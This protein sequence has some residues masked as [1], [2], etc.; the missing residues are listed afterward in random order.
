MTGSTVVSET[1]AGN[2]KI[3]IARSTYDMKG[4]FEGIWVGETQRI[5]IDLGT[6][7]VAGEELEAT[8]TGTVLGKH[9]SFG[10]KD[11]WTVVDDYLFGPFEILKGTGTGDLANLQGKG[12]YWGSA[13][14]EK[15]EYSAWIRF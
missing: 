10:I 8:F 1:V 3:I 9:G 2:K 15:G 6:G 11:K 12:T 5:V 4:D 13:K 7:N 14:Q